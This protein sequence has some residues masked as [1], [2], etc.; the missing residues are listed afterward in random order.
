MKRILS[1]ALLLL[2]ALTLAACG[3][4]KTA[5]EPNAV[6]MP[7]DGGDEALIQLDP[8]DPLASYLDLSKLPPETVSAAIQELNLTSEAGGCQATLQKALGDAMT[9]YLSLDVTYP[10]G[11]DLSDPSMLTQGSDYRSSDRVVLVEGTITD[12]A[13]IPDKIS[14]TEISSV[15]FQGTQTGDRTANYL[16]TISYREAVLTPGKE[17][18][19]LYEDRLLDVTHLFHWTIENQAPVQQAELTDQD[20]NVAGTGVLSPFAACL[21]IQDNTIATSMEPDRLLDQLAFLDASGVPID[22]F[23]GTGVNNDSAP[24]LFEAMAFVPVS[25][26]QLAAVQL[27]EHTLNIV[28]TDGET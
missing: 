18:T 8:S 16:I 10:E 7:T 28:W 5:E 19:L 2:F 15:S 22:G 26:D 24:M 9:L 12:P 3:G 11:T 1:L 4:E 20:G 6:P 14:D 17:V 27:G 25:L 13:Q 21:T 23:R